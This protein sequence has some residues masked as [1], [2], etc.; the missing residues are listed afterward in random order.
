MALT[1]YIIVL[2]ITKEL[3]KSYKGDSFTTELRK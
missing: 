2:D 1:L 3:K